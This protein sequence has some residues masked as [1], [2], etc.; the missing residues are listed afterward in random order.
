MWQLITEFLNWLTSLWSGLPPST[1]KE[2]IDRA[3]DLLGEV[4]RAIFKHSTPAQA[5]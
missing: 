4:L 5:M 2:I 3:V 1:K